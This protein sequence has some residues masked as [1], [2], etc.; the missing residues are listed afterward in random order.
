MCGWTSRAGVEGA[1]GEDKGGQE[2]REK[3]RHLTGTHS[4]PRAAIRLAH[5]PLGNPLPPTETLAWKLQMLQEGN[6]NVAPL[7]SRVQQRTF[8]LVRAR[9]SGCV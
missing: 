5:V 3:R 7:L 6:E 4:H 1:A 9:W 2:T 8:V